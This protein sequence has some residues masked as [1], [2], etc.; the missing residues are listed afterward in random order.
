MAQFK[1]QKF[2]F[3]APRTVIFLKKVLKST[4]SG[5]LLGE[6]AQIQSAYPL[7]GRCK[8][9]HASC[10]FYYFFHSGEYLLHFCG[11][12]TKFLEKNHEKLCGIKNYAYLCT[13]LTALR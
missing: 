9:L 1:T 8:K 12:N 11:K 6:K 13:R 10:F 3:F 5:F 7:R 2:T 4:K